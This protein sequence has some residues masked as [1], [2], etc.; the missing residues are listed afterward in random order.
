[1]KNTD[2]ARKVKRNNG[3]MFY[4]AWRRIIPKINS[5]NDLL[6]ALSKQQQDDEEDE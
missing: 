2:E 5:F 1:M 3:S 6:S 4:V